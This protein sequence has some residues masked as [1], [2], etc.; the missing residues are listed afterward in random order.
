[1]SKIKHIFRS[2][3]TPEGKYIGYITLVFNDMI[4]NSY[5]IAD[6]N[7]FTVLRD[8][9]KWKH[10]IIDTYIGYKIKKDSEIK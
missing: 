2:G 3:T 10:K 4:C 8:I 6:K 9:V 5:G 1:M 7:K